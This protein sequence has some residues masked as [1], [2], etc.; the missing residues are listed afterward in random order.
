VNLESLIWNSDISLKRP[1]SLRVTS[2]EGRDIA[3][4]GGTFESLVA[5][6]REI[7]RYNIVSD[8]NHFLPTRRST[9]NVGIETI[10]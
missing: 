7:M 9:R 10:S 5:D 2:I 1:A 3:S 6:E 4:G 8:Q